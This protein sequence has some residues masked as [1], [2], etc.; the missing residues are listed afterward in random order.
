MLIWLGFIELGYTLYKH[1]PQDLEVRFRQ[2]DVLDPG[3]F[4]KCKDLAGQFDFVHSANVIHLFNE[5]QQEAFIQA[6]VF[7][8]KPGGM[9]WGRQVGL[10]DNEDGK[11]ATER[12]RQP[13][14][15]GTRFTIAQFRR[16]WLRATGWDANTLKFEAELVPYDELRDQRADKRFVLQWSIRAAKDDCTGRVLDED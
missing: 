2:A 14:G 1:R 3:F 13:E 15:K 8:V 16:L 7:L 11:E 9:V 12:F 6:L 10:E 4:K 5:T